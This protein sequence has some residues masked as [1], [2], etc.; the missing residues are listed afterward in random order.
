MVHPFEDATRDVQTHTPC[1][2][3]DHSVTLFPRSVG[4]R[5]FL[6]IA[7]DLAF[8]LANL[9]GQQAFAGKQA[10]AVNSTRLYPNEI[11]WTLLQKMVQPMDRHVV[12]H[13]V[14]MVE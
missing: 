10:L 2:E 3:E 9:A 12:Q 6:R 7:D 4:T 5:F 8:K 1:C 11:S 14:H 13:M